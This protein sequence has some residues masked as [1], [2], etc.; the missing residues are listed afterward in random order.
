MAT[1]THWKSLWVE[2]SG[3][4]TRFIKGKKYTHRVIEAGAGEPLILIHGIGGHAEGYARNVMNLAKNFHVYS[5]DALY[6]G[7]TL[8][9]NFDHE[10]TTYRQAEAI[11]DLL[12]A[13]GHKWAHIK[14]ESMG[15][16]IAFEYGMYFPERAGK[17]IL[18]TGAFFIDFKRT[19]KVQAGGGP[20][21]FDLSR[22]AV[23]NPNPITL[24]KRLE[25]LVTS[26]DR[27]TDEIV[28]LR[29]KMYSDPAINASMRKVF[30][31]DVPQEPRLRYT[32]ED[33]ANLK[34]PTM[35]FWT[36]NNPGA[37][38]DV[39][40]HFASLIPGSKYYCMADAA[41][42]PMWE[43]PGEHDRVTTQFLQGK[44]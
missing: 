41:H 4:Q 43:H 29:L 9:D 32:E 21:L 24:R 28:D 7:Y 36:E 20:L 13:E 40:E 22:E 23:T 1:E 14:G 38:P 31:I 30:G 26:P 27:I 42:W 16:H 6:H 25:W 15:S 39:G 11:V 10:Q 17:L 35:V 34:P 12:D 18:D 5:I 37:G 44:M 19:F 3:S 2:L 8:S 33:C